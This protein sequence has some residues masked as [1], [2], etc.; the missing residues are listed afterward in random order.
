MV[1]PGILGFGWGWYNMDS[2]LCDLA[3]GCGVDLLVGGLWGCLWL[4]G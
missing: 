2:C 4:V 3:F 1:F